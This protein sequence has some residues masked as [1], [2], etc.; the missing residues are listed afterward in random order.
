MIKA[1]MVMLR[2][3]SDIQI[4]FVNKDTYDWI[5][6]G[7]T[8]SEA[9]IQMYMKHTELTREETLEELND[10]DGDN[11]RALAVNGDYGPGQYNS[12]SFFDITKAMKFA[13]DN[14]IEVVESYEG[15]IY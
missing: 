1:Y 9:Q 3:D 15:Y 10:C 5:L 12:N 7:G 11:D 2:G 8:P 6:N 13:R 14:D 4:H